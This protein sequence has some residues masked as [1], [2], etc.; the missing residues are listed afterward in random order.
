[1]AA[2]VTATLTRQQMVL[3][4]RGI[5]LTAVIGEAA[6]RQEVGGEAALRGQRQLADTN[7]AVC[8]M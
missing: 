2:V 7:P 4:E 3:R 8:A 5:G 1:L 6:L